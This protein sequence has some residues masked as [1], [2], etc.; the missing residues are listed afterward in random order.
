MYETHGFS[1]DGTQILFSGAEQEGHYYD[2]EIYVMDLTTGVTV[3]LTDND[4]WDEHAHFTPDGQSIVWVS[5]EGIH[6][7]RGVSLEDALDNPPKLEYWIMNKDGSDKC[8][9]SGFNY[10]GAPEYIDVDGGIGLGD[11]C[12]G[13]DGKTIVAK[14]RRGFKETVIVL[15]EF[16]V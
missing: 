9:L 2:M 3:Q 8:R 16:D 13:P 11:Y 7:E 1:P 5:T 12:M 4:E 15:I 14:M 10:A 6:Q